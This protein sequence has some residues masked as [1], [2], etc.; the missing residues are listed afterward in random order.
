[1]D[2]LIGYTGFVGS[3]ILEQ[4][5]FDAF[6]NSSNID[7]IRGRSFDL[8]VSAGTPALMWLANKDSAS[9]WDGIR[10][11]I[12]AL[13]SVDARRFVL[14]S[15]IEVYPDPAGV[16]EDSPVDTA[17]Q[18]PYGKHRYLLEQFVHDRF[19]ALI[20]RLPNLF[21]NRL[22]KNVLYDLLTNNQL[23]KV[24]A[25]SRFQ[26]Y[27]LEY[28]WR[29]IA[30]A[31]DSGIK[32][33]NMATEPVT[34]R[35]LAHCATGVEFDNRPR[36]QTPNAYDY[37]SK[38]AP[39]WRM[40]DRYQY[41]KEDVLQDIAE[42]ADRFRR[43]SLKLAVS[44]IGW[45]A[46]D[47]P[48]MREVLRDFGVSGVEL[49]PDRFV[50]ERGEP[51]AAAIAR[52]VEFWIGAGIAPVALQG[53]LFSKGHLRLFESEAG[54]RELAAYARRMVAVA[55]E[56]GV[57]VVVFGSPK[58]RDRGGLSIDAADAVAVPLFRELAEC[59]YDHGITLC[60]EH[61][62]LEYGSDYIQ[63]PADAV[64][65]ARRVNHPGFGVN[66]DTG[67][68]LL[69]GGTSQT[70]LDCGGYIR[71]VHISQP[72]LGPVDQLDPAAHEPFATALRRLKYSGWV[73]IEMKRSGGRDVGQIR[74]SIERVRQI[75]S[76]RRNG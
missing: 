54:R 68:L 44:T 59:A 40:H 73:S 43:H 65:L 13:A 30:L 39:L 37:R 51:D 71:H 50:D 35:E 26:Y 41:R 70:I 72:L 45:S 53:L 61:L 19:D 28:L 66:L 11:L 8:L 20:V 67:A 27:N 22:K 47:D 7:E 57:S 64:R 60:V 56:L 9:D 75:Y 10:R 3:H 18:R 31:M 74:R 29:D 12:A 24:H 76:G 63:T 49:V 5:R 21:G 6:Y 15:T 46:G 25:D 4:R 52:C 17:R 14:I 36:A 42:F 34:V 33:L 16:D 38:H 55:A 69:A 23:E 58:C 32:L 1:M 2:G 48:E 62:P